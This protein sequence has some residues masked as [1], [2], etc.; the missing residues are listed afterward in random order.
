MA[1]RISELEALAGKPRKTSKNS[2]IPPSKDDFGTG[3]SCG[4]RSGKSKGG[5]RPS[6]EGKHRLLAEA[7]D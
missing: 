2:H 3:G 6:R 5:K 7:P 1:A 4:G